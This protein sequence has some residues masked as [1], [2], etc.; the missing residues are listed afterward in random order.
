MTYADLQALGRAIFDRGFLAD[1]NLEAKKAAVN[2][3]ATVAEIDS[4]TLEG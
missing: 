3:A 1:Q 2:A 4:I